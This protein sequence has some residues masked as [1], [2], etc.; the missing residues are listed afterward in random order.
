MISSALSVLNQHSIMVVAT[1]RSDGWPQA[2]TVC[3][4]NDGLAVYFLISR[5]S[6]KFANIGREGRVSIAIGDGARLP[7]QIRGLSMAA[8]AF[9][10]RDE[11]YRSEVLAKLSARHPDYFDAATFDM[12]GSALMRALPRIVSVVDFSQGLGHSEALSVGADQIAAF[13]AATPNNWGFNPAH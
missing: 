1:M 10:V 12:A 7:S 11:P 13:T 4:V 5:T 3:Y 6:Q 9:E 2:T 8:E